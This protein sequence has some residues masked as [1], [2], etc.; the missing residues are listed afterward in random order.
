MKK[1]TEA[2][3]ATFKAGKV[4]ERWTWHHH[5]DTGVMQLVLKEVH[6]VASHTGGFSIW[7]P[8]N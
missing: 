4:P 5:Q 3:I 7:G 2:E 6:E 8:G 1:F